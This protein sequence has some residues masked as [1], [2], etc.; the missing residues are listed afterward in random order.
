[1]PADDDR[2]RAFAT[3]H[4]LAHGLGAKLSRSASS[5][6][7]ERRYSRDQYRS[8]FAMACGAILERTL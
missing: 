7:S 1:M 5:V 2:F 3:S 8:A 4:F 6:I